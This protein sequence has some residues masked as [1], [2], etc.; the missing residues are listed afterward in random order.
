[1]KV[2]TL[3]EMLVIADRHKAPELKVKLMHFIEQNRKLVIKTEGW[4]M[5]T[6]DYL[7]LVNE[8]FGQECVVPETELEIKKKKGLKRKIN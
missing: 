4:K 3:C 8:L 2:D 5:L 6:Q 1:M 7:H